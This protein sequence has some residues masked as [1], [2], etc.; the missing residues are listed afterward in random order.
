M[1]STHVY[2]QYVYIIDSY[3]TYINTFTV[4][5]NISK[6]RNFWDDFASV[7]M[8]GTTLDELKEIFDHQIEG[9]FSYSYNDV[10]RYGYHMP[11]GIK[12]WQIVL[13]LDESVVA[14]RVQNLSSV[15]TTSFAL[16]WIC[17]AVML[18]CL[19]SYFKSTNRKICEANQQISKNNEVL[20]IAVESSGRIIFEYNIHDKSVELKTAMPQGLFDSTVIPQVPDHFIDMNIVAEGSIAAL[21][22]LFDR[23]ATETSGQADIQL[24][25]GA[26][27]PAWYQISLQNIYDEHGEIITTVG[28]AED[29]SLLKKGEVAIKRREEMHRSLIKTS[30]LYG[31]VDLSTGIIHELNG[32]ETFLP[33]TDF[34]NE[35]IPKHVCEEYRLYVM[36]ALSLSTLWEA[37]QQKKEYVEVQYQRDEE[38]NKKWTSILIYR[39]HKSE[40]SFVTFV[41]RDI[42]EQKRSEI[43]LRE[44]AEIDGLTGLYN[45]ATT[46][47]KI[48]Q[49]LSVP[50]S[51]EENQIFILF[52]LDNFKKIND[53]FGHSTGDQVL[54][55]VGN[56]LKQHFRSTDIV[57]RLGGDE[58]IAMLCD[59]KSDHYVDI[60]A[61]SLCREL[62]QTYTQENI[63]ITVS[64]SIGIAV[65]PQDGTTFEELYKK[66]DAALYQVKKSGKNGYR[67]WQE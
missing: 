15:A 60:I 62:T 61:S 13:S 67:L 9:D 46:R 59:V 22:D 8:N 30:L 3:G 34:L 54:I 53:N 17:L 33:Y 48:K 43:A 28:R 5:Q 18:W 32:K 35:N 57:G 39:V 29:I 51:S 7:K 6:G 27:S 11:L 66:S 58:F 49:L 25:L 36:Q 38:H 52:D 2:N 63:S 16:N 20:K 10:H 12:D 45:S 37:Y 4:E 41:V 44:Q 50:H 19:Y 56:K 40:G 31:R 24:L 14:N 47:S 23:I 55:D 26:E 64:A 21:R 65:A 1:D 42:D